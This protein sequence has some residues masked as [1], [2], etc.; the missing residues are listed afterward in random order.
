ME[1]THRAFWVPIS[2]PSDLRCLIWSSERWDG[3]KAVLILF[4]FFFLESWIAFWAMCSRFIR[5]RR[6]KADRVLMWMV[7]ARRALTHMHSAHVCAVK[8]LW[9]RW[10]SCRQMLC[11]WKNGRVVSTSSIH[12]IKPIITNKH[13]N[14]NHKNSFCLCVSGA[15]DHKK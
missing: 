4:V 7:N 9:N 12:T 13:K 6:L 15:H 3:N 1:N 2:M 5:Q 10:H 11:A 8:H 14:K